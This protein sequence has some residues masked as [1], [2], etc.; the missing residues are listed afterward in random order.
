MHHKYLVLGTDGG[1]H[2]KRS[3]DINDAIA[4]GLFGAGYFVIMNL[5]F[6]LCSPEVML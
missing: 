6:P 1:R 4:S 5:P 2:K 3:N